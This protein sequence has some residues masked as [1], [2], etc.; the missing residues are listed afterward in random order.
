MQHARDT[1]ALILAY[2]LLHETFAFYFTVSILAFCEPVTAILA[3]LRQQKIRIGTLDLRIAA[4]ALAAGAI[5]V[6]CNQRGFERVSVL[7]R[8][9]VWIFPSVSG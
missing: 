4:T 2:Y 1:A 6:T 8:G 9:L 5:L 7:M 3:G